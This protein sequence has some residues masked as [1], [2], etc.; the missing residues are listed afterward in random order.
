LEISEAPAVCLSLL[1]LRGD[2]HTAEDIKFQFRLIIR[3]I[4]RRL[5]ISTAAT[6]GFDEIS[7]PR[8]RPP[9]MDPI[10]A[11]ALYYIILHAPGCVQIERC[12]VCRTLKP[13]SLG[14][15]YL[16]TSA[17][18]AYGD[19]NFHY[20]IIVASAD[21]MQRGHAAYLDSI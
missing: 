15:V 2:L 20:A 7:L 12:C 16:H 8:S 5:F 11:N 18:A 9:P 1:L 10:V 6:L 3:L 21:E 14:G 17:Q 4:D 19:I 13:L